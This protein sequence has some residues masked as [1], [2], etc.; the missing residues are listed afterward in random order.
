MDT[1]ERADCV[2]QLEQVNHLEVGTGN[3]IY[4]AL[5][6]LLEGF[7]SYVSESE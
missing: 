7:L 2:I 3:E 6:V 4:S 5:A 1:T